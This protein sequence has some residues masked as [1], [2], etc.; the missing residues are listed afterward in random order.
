M[1]TVDPA[2]VVAQV[3]VLMAVAGVVVAVSV[4]V[5]LNLACSKC[6]EAL[7]VVN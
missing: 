1:E 3:A 6:F 4:V 5:K 7:S 2:A